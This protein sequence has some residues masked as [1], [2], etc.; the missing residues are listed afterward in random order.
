MTVM[1]EHEDHIDGGVSH[2]LP[3]ILSRRRALGG[4]LGGASLAFL[5]AACGSS[6]DVTAT[7]SATQ[8][9]TP[10]GP[11][12]GMPPGGSSN[13]SVADGEIPEETAGPFP[14]D[15]SNGA[16]VLTESG[17]VRSDITKS[18][19]GA[20]GVATGVP[21]TIVLRLVELDGTTVTPKEGAA[22]YLWHADQQGRYSLYSQGVTDENYLRGVQAADK[23]GTITFQS[24]FPACYDGRWP[25]IH[26]EVYESVAKATSS[27]NKLRTS[28]L[29]LPKDVCD[30]VYATSGYEQS[31]SALSRVSLDSDGVFS[32]GYSL[33]L[34]TVTGDVSSGLTATLTV[35]V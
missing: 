5:A 12:G 13:V 30:T 2:D 22:V 9:T 23:E 31:V 21:L 33:Q 27:A 11:P 16:N 17:V 8:A 14:G 34:A 29:A 4:V 35:P 20:S 6:G 15:G 26:F 32:D 3:R 24:V 25:H 18:I 7:A 1:S 10:G 28:Q 19:G